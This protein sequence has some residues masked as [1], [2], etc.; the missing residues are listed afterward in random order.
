[1]ETPLAGPT[2][3]LETLPVV[4]DDFIA[5]NGV[6]HSWVCDPENPEYDTLKYCSW[7]KEGNRSQN[8]NWHPFVVNVGPGVQR[9][10]YP[11]ADYYRFDCK[12]RQLL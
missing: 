12:T 2:G 8:D 7:R 9:R 4:E 1:M 11:R 3:R 5:F 6:N 10:A